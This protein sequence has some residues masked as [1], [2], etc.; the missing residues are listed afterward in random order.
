MTL[1]PCYGW[2][3]RGQPVCV[4]YEAPQGRR[5]NTLGALFSHGPLAGRFDFE[6][7]ASLPKSRAKNKAKKDTQRRRLTVEQIAAAHGLTADEVGPIDAERFLSFVWR[8][9]GR[10]KVYPLGWQRERPLVM[11]VDNYSVHVSQLVKEALPELAAANIYLFYL[12]PYSPELSDIEPVWQTVKHHEMPERSH[13]EVRD[14]KWSVE[15]ALTRKA[16]ALLKA[17]SEDQSEDQPRK[18]RTLSALSKT[19]NLLRMTA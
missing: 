15:E 12:P 14:L 10:P 7:Y 5:V 18:S 16:D 3:P 6:V 1:P 13:S 9:A 19:D 17:N 4:A 2:S 11:V 8:V